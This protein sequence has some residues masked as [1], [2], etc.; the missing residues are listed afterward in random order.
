MGLS[1]ETYDLVQKFGNEKAIA[2]RQLLD[3][4]NLT[5]GAFYSTLSVWVSTSLSDLRNCDLWAFYVGRGY[6]HADAVSFQAPLRS[7]GNLS[8]LQPDRREY[9]RALQNKIAKTTAPDTRGGCF[10]ECALGGVEDVA[11]YNFGALRAWPL[12][13]N[14]SSTYNSSDF[15]LNGFS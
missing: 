11:P 6:I 14:H 2:I 4:N 12:A 15:H 1:I 13:T 10:A 9:I 5:S 8:K 3:E 7:F